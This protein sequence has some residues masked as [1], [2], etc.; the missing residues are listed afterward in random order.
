VVIGKHV[1]QTAS[2]LTYQIEK[3]GN[4]EH[5]YD[6]FGGGFFHH[7]VSVLHENVSTPPSGD[8]KRYRPP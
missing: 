7:S 1:S 5:S 6:Q 2:K 8:R 3:T 4:N